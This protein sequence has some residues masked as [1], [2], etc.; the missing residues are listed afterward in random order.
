MSTYPDHP[1]SDPAIEA[2]AEWRRLGDLDDSMQ[3]Y[4][5]AAGRPFPDGLAAKFWQDAVSHVK[6]TTVIGALA[7]LEECIEGAE[8]PELLRNAIAFLR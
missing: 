8:Q 5:L 6:P 3:Q 2:L 7:L 1:K 4:C